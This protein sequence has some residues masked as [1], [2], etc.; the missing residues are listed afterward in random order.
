M[1]KMILSFLGFLCCLSANGQVDLSEIN[2]II[3][4]AHQRTSSNISVKTRDVEIQID[5]FYQYNYMN[6]NWNT[7]PTLKVYNDFN[8][9]GDLILQDVYQDDGAGNYGNIQ[10]VKL[11]YENGLNTVQTVCNYNE[12][13]M[14]WDVF[15]SIT[16][17]YN[18]DDLLAVQDIAV[19]FGQFLI[20]VRGFNYYSPEN[21]LDSTVQDVS[22]DGVTFQYN[23]TVHFSY[24]E[25]GNLVEQFAEGIDGNTGAFGPISLDSLV[26]DEYSRHVETYSSEHNGVSWDKVSRVTFEIDDFGFPLEEVTSNYEASLDSYV[27]DIKNVFF[28]EY[29]TGLNETTLVDCQMVNP[30]DGHIQLFCDPLSD[31]DQIVL[32]VFDLHGKKIISQVMAGND[33]ITLDTQLSSGMYQLIVHNRKDLLVSQKLMIQK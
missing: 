7:D 17:T 25:N 6:E 12:G 15:V 18:D 20:F 9:D 24:D 30:S 2:Q 26:Y 16:N 33:L 31:Q 27:K 13:T 22:F 21:V 29:T 28:F 19:D 10:Q 14:A 1:N 5:S 4:E 8:M 23:S 32:E 11:E 3:E